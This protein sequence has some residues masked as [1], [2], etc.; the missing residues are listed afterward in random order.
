VNQKDDPR[1]LIVIPA[2]NEARNLPRVVSGLRERCAKWDIVVVDDGSWDGT[3]DIADELG[4]LVL[5]LPFNLGIGGAVQTGLKLAALRDYDV[6]VQVDADGQHTAAAT[7]QLIRALWESGV[8]AVI[9]SRFL[10]SSG[11]RS[12]RSRRIGIRIL[13]QVIRWLT[14]KSV[15]DPT[16]GHRAFGRNSIACLAA[17]YPQ[18]YPEPEA[19]Y[20]L[21]RDGLRVK[22][23]PVEMHARQHGKSS[24]SGADSVLYMAKVLLAILIHNTRPS[25]CSEETST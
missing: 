3:G 1:V 20:R 10:A 24:I 4:T 13:R 17:W 7:E 15:T 8:D 14:G 5:R 9:G 18:E 22:E 11:F 6:C 19:V 2:Y 23:I 16:S 21:L 25:T 12:T